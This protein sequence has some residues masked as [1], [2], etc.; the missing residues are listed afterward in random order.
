MSSG[1]IA[2]FQAEANTDTDALQEWNDPRA[3]GK[4]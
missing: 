2:E 3:N 4:I 1:D